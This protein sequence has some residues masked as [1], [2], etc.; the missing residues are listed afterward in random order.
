MGAGGTDSDAPEEVTKEWAERQLESYIRLGSKT[1][2]NQKSKINLDDVQYNQ[3]WWNQY[4]RDNN[5]NPS[6]GN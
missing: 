1:D 2:S 5:I 6:S 3:K 4:C